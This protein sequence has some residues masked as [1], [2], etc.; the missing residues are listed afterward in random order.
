MLFQQ[1]RSLTCHENYKNK[2]FNSGSF[3]GCHQ[4]FIYYAAVIIGRITSLGRPYVR[5]SCTGSQIEN[6]KSYIEKTKIGQKMFARTGVTGMVCQCSAQKVKGQWADGRT[7]VG[8]R[9]TYF[10]RLF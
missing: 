8:T 5:P 9:S 2:K 7:Y 4:L 3:S 1:H 6:K 10:S